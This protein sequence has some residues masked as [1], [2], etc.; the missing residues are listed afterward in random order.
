[1]LDLRNGYSR[2]EQ[3]YINL[4]PPRPQQ[5]L[6]SEAQ[7]EDK[8]VVIIFPGHFPSFQQC[9]VQ[10]HADILFLTVLS[11][12]FFRVSQVVFCIHINA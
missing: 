5:Q 1:M 7:G 6:I 11:G 12:I 2:S 8:Q 9:A 10:R 4:L 3:G